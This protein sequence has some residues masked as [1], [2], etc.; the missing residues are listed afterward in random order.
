[1]G[2]PSSERATILR[3]GSG[4]RRGVLNGAH[5]SCPETTN[6]GA[7]KGKKTRNGK[8]QILWRVSSDMEKKNWHFGGAVQP[9]PIR[10]RF[11]IALN[12]KNL[13]QIS[14]LKALRSDSK[15]APLP[16]RKQ[17]HRSNNSL[18][19]LIDLRKNKRYVCF[20][21]YAVDRSLATTQRSKS[22]C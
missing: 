7:F 10:C 12:V 17:K 3:C 20:K 5:L 21:R 2:N 16:K 8:S 22:Y 13:T 14:H 6:I 19:L 18:L 1:M 15:R 9:C 11:G 4:S